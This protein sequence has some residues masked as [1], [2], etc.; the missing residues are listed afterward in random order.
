M[1]IRDVP[2]LLGIVYSAHAQAVIGF[3]SASGTVRD[4]TGSGIPDTTVVVSNERMGIRRSMETSDE[5]VFNAT[6]LPAGPG[7]DLKVTRVGF[8]DLE[9]PNFEILVGHSLNFKISLAQKAAADQT[10]SEKPGIEVEDS[11]FALQRTFPEFEVDS[12]PTRDRNVNTLAPL[13]LGTTEDHASGQLIFHGE[14]FTNA[15]LT[16]GIWTQNAYYYN[17]APIAPV[18]SQDATEELQIVAAGASAEFGHSMGGTVNVVTRSGGSAIHGSLYD[19]FN[20]HSLNAADKFAPGFTPPG[21]Q[22]QFGLTAGGPVGWKNLFWYVNLEDVDG[23]SEELNR[24]SNQLLVDPSGTAIL[25]SNCTASATQCAPT[26]AFLN[27]QLNRVVQSSVASLGGLAKLDWRLNDSNAINI[28]VDATHRHSP[29][30]TNTETVASNAGLLGYNGTYTDESRYAKAG[31]TAVWSGNAVND[32]RAG[33]YHDRFSD[34]ENASSLPTTGA[35]GIDLA[36]TPFGG[37]PNLPVALSEQRYQIVDNFTATLGSNLFKLGLDYSTTEDNNEQ[38]INRFGNY[39]YPTLTTFAEDFAGN[40]ALHKDYTLFNQTFGQPVVDLHTARMG[41]YAQDTWRPGRRITID[42]GILFEKTFIPQPKDVN[43]TFIQTGSIASP[44]VDFAPRIGLGY[45]IDR[46]TVIRL[47]LGSYYQPFSGQLLEALYTGNA[48]FQLPVTVTATQT[49]SP[50]FPKI[51]TSPGAATAG[52]TDATYAVS[53]FR[54][55]LSAQGTI[56]IERYLGRDWTLSL[57]DLFSRGLELWTA[58]EQ[59]LNAPTITRTYTIDNAAG[60]AVSTY[61][62][63]LYTSKVNGDF[64]HVY[65]VQNSGNSSYNAASI[66]LRK[67][68]SHGLAA[69]ASYTWSH[70]TDDVSGT[71][72]VAGFIASTSIPGASHNDK[73][74]S[75]FNQPNRIVATWTWEPKIANSDHWEVRYIINGWRISGSAIVASSL[76]ETPIAVLSGQQFTGVSMVFPT[77]LNGSGGWSRVPFEQ[78]NSLLTNRQYD[79]DAR[80]TRDIPFG[81][82]I[83]ARLML[84]AFNALN[85][86]YNTSVNTIAYLATSGVLRPVPGVGVGNAADGF[87]WGDNARHLQVALQIVF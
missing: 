79:V 6:A 19:Y 67:R 72:V 47:G 49:G 74:N 51:P 60:A 84:E 41:I 85:T 50:V 29:N 44:N 8:L 39:F 66:Q 28:E 2:I 37:N 62:T 53:K 4:Y 55:P 1:K 10:T 5:G 82:R 21:W 3:G 23:H 71:P 18:V 38:I 70:A 64:A 22:H 65:Q 27:S 52:V 17:Q 35:V 24:T 68:M 25:A 26:I 15:F 86:Q 76:P 48:I 87:P 20:T 63:L 78:V 12:L 13:S 59:N 80:L 83:K 32:V 34:F 77:S 81:E 16:D 54:S 73:G 7:Y 9:Y 69:Q 46:R 33:W 36:G 31:Y 57:N 75:S 58:P 11:V 56:T 45:Q 43:P 30:G 61:S 40:A 14:A 42:V